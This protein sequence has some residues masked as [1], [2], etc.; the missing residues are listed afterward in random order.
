MRTSAFVPTFGRFAVKTLWKIAIFHPN[1]RTY[2]ETSIHCS[3]FFREYE[4]KR[5]I[6]QCFIQTI[7]CSHILSVSHNAGV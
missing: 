1:T 5:V 4:I 2:E 6:Y 7:I 3:V